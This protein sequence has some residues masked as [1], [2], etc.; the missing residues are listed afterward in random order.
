MHEQ[1]QIYTS[2]TCDTC[3]K[4]YVWWGEG[5]PRFI[6]CLAPLFKL[7]P[8]RT[9]VTTKT[10]FSSVVCCWL[11]PR[12]PASIKDLGDGVQM[13]VG[14]NFKANQHLTSSPPGGKLNLSSQHGP[15][16]PPLKTHVFLFCS[17]LTSLKEDWIR[18]SICNTSI[19]LL[20]TPC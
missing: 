10:S 11:C 16:L 4:F 5:V 6:L 18:Y 20:T 8:N 13:G 15:P 12:R 19:W 9:K 14:G 7:S 2:V 3:N 17:P 1:K